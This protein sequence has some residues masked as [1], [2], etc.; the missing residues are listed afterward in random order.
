M[1]SQFGIDLEGSHVAAVANLLQTRHPWFLDVESLIEPSFALQVTVLA[2]CRTGP[3]DRLTG[4][5]RAR[6][7]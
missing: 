2:A 1:L 6:F 5:G 4:G 3:R 7:L